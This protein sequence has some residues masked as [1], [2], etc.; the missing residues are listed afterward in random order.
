MLKKFCRFVD[1]HHDLSAVILIAVA[2]FAFF[3]PSLPFEKFA[4]DDTNYV[5]QTHLFELT[6][7]NIR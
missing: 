6:F 3:L 7:S 5:G 4:F 2:V 1:R